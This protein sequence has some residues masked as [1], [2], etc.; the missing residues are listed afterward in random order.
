MGAGGVPP[1]SAQPRLTTHRGGRGRY[2]VGVPLD[3]AAVSGALPN[4]VPF[5][6]TMGLEFVSL[7]DDAAVLRLP[8]DRATRNHVGGQ[9]AGAV[10]TLGE[11]AAGSLVLRHFGE[12]LERVTPLAVEATIRYLA[13]S[14]GAVTATATMADDP[15]R[16]LSVLDGGER[17]EFDVDVVLHSD[18]VD[19]PLERTAQ[20]TV[21][22][23]LRPSP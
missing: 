1:G 11:T 23:T 21:R 5:V 6:G 19:E 22:W 15:A 12:L 9:H 8:D 4:L 10:F 2:P 3:L 17:P 13:L 14:K 20:M 7:S 18:E 16:I